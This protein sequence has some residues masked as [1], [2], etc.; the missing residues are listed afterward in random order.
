MLVMEAIS[1]ISDSQIL[2]T[3]NGIAGVVQSTQQFY[4]APRG[5]HQ[6][7]VP[8]NNELPSTNPSGDA[9]GAL[10]S[11]QMIGAANGGSL[12]L[13]LH[14]NDQSAPKLPFSQQNNLIFG[15]QANEGEG[16][17]PAM[18]QSLLLR[19][20]QY[21][22]H[23]RGSDSLVHSDLSGKATALL[24]PDGLRQ[25]TPVPTKDNW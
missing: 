8:P 22:K 10:V 15:S 23:S 2:L 13:V 18:S 11:Q 14:S 6:G 24:P 12:N 7:M 5:S 3:N 25:S 19:P 9:N 20:E 21:I 1:Q 16:L 17:W 4:G